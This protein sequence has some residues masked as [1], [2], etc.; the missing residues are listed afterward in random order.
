[1][2]PLLSALLLCAGF[3]AFVALAS[4]RIEP[5]AVREGQVALVIY[6]RVVLVKGLLPQLALAL[7]LGPAIAR[8]PALAGARGAPS[9]ARAI[10]A[11]GVAALVVAATLMPL[12][13]PSLPAVKFRGPG[14][15]VAT[16][17]EMTGAVA[18]ALWIPERWLARRRARAAATG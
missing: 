13:L 10:L 18:A 3:L 4:L 8:I 11:A 15:F 2:R 16:A 12:D 6:A 17:L 7:L 9:A 1:V 14:N 5:D